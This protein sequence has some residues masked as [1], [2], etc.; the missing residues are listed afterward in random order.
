[1]AGFAV[2]NRPHENVLHDIYVKALALCDSAG[3]PAVLLTSDLLGFDRATGDYLAQ[4]AQQR[5]GLAR[6]RLVLNASH[7]HSGPVTKG[8][9]DTYHGYDAVMERTVAD[10]TGWLHEQVLEAIGEALDTMALAE[11]SFGQGLAGFATNRRR[12]RPGRRSWPNVVDHDV[13]VLAV[14]GSSGELR[15]VV[16]GY[17]CHTTTLWGYDICGD[18]AGF[19][20]LELE[21]AHPGA[22]CLFVAG[23]GGDSNPLPR[24]ELH[25]CQGYGHILAQ[26]VELVLGGVMTPLSGPLKTAFADVPLPLESPPSLPELHARLQRYAGAETGLNDFYARVESNLLQMLEN[27]GRWPAHVS[28][29]VQVWQFGADLKFIALSGEPVA[30][31]ALRFKHQYGWDNTWV[32]GYSTDVMAYVPSRRVRREGDYEGETGMPEYG[33]PSPFTEGVEELIAAQVATLC[34]QTS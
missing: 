27:G 8:L 10:Y 7:N 9:L 33:W 18:Y 29:P 19:A 28:Y 6:D 5:F 11:L 17:A 4:Q 15:V 12:S 24:R 16:F 32:S 14:H 31:Y 26:A 21:Q 1:M 2:R 22:T 25:L 30:D 13:P 3:Q 34:A 23:C 20:Q